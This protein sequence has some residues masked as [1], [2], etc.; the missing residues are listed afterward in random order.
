MTKNF[1]LVLSLTAA[2]FTTNA[3]AEPAPVNTDNFIRAESD[4]YF[5]NLVA[6]GSFGTIKHTREMAP[7]DHQTVVRLNR[8]TLYS[9]GIFDLDAGAVTVRLPDTG[10][11]FISMQLVDEDQF[12]PAVYY[13]PG[14]YTFTREQIGTRYLLV[15]IRILADPND[16]TDMET[17]H[18]IQDAIV[19]KQVNQGNF[20]TPQWDSASRDSIRA[21]L[22]D[23]GRFLPDSKRMFGSRE[24]VDQVRHLIGTAVGWGG[25]PEKDALYIGR[26]EPQNDGTTAYRLKIGNVPV[27]GFW[28][29]S[30]Y[31]A[32]GYFEKNDRNAYTVNNV[33]ADKAAD[34]SVTIQF[35]NC[36]TH[37]PNCLPITEGWNYTVRLY[38]PSA[39]ILNGTWTFPEATIIK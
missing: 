21:A 25:N 6:S 23:L 15:A 14:E 12:S 27:E 20:D 19:A 38:R 34:D 26:T 17:V 11:R 37:I 9:S 32:K 8:D 28:S 7:I 4:L 2:F 22:R 35:G 10:N 30:V 36:T 33:T 16:K 5:S 31:N 1:G 39:D 24:D 18:K 13:A 29:V 3:F